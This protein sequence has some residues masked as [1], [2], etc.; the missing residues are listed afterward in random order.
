MPSLCESHKAILEQVGSID[1]WYHGELLSLPAVLLGYFEYETKF[2][3]CASRALKLL[4]LLTLLP[5][6]GGKRNRQLRSLVQGEAIPRRQVQLL[7]RH[8]HQAQPVTTGPQT[9]H[10]RSPKLWCWFMRQDRGDYSTVFA[11]MCSVFVSK[12]GSASKSDGLRGLERPLKRMEDN[13]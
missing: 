8:L 5:P 7:T 12:Q 13:R 3:S 4:T 6:Q 10:S 2:S 9:S 11:Q 1:K